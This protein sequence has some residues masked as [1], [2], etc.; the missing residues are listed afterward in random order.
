MIIHALIDGFQNVQNM[1]TMLNMKGTPITWG[2]D[3]WFNEPWKVEK[4]DLKHLVY[5]PFKRVSEDGGCEV[6][7]NHFDEKLKHV[8]PPGA[9]HV[10]VDLI[11]DEL[12]DV[13]II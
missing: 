13:A 3:S 9:T 10:E 7:W 11:T 4:D 12:G 2:H 8:P 1:L 5:V 6:F